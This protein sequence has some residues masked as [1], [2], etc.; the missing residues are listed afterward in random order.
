MIQL[1]NTENRFGL[2]SIIMHWVMAVMIITLLAVGLTLDQLASGP[3]KTLIIGIHKE[4]GLLVL[5]L[6]IVRLSWRIINSSPTLADLPRWEKLT[7]RAVHAAFYLLMFTQP[8]SGWAMSSAGG[9]PISFFG[10]FIVPPLV[11]PDSQLKTFFASAH[12]YQG[13]A[14]IVLCLL[15]V[16]A[17][18]KHHYLDKDNILKRMLRPE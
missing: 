7:A 9:H 12:E 4:V 10:L 15:H 18:L 2:I 5:M 13:Y 16:A 11:E 17:A 3:Q 1:K 8:L 6:V 14:L